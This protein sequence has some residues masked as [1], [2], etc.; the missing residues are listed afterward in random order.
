M[1]GRLDWTE[2]LFSSAGRMS[3]VPFMVCAGV[4]LTGAWLYQAVTVAPQNSRNG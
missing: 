1:N 3:R 2:L 4:L